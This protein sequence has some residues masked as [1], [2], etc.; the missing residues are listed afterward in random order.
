MNRF[1]KEMK[2]EVRKLS[3]EAMNILIRYHWPGNVKGASECVREGSGIMYG[4]EIW[5]GISLLTCPS[6][7]TGMPD[8]GFHVA[9]KNLKRNLITDVF[10][11]NNGSQAKDSRDAR[12]S[13]DLPCKTDKGLRH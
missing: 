8:A 3:E 6:S 7:S 12:P 11:K 4:A 13:K 5:R 10:K 2:K 9:V 1:S